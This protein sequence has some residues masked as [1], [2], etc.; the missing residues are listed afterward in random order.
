[1]PL[2]ISQMGMKNVGGLLYSLISRDIS[3]LYHSPAT[4]V[5]VYTNLFSRWNFPPTLF[6]LL[7][8]PFSGVPN[9]SGGFHRTLSLCSAT[10]VVAFC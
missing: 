1:M 3:L 5:N 2:M 4:P 6:N 7:F 9:L 10:R 8:L